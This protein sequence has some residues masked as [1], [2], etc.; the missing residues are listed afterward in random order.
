MSDVCINAL[1]ELELVV[2]H[3]IDAAAK[4]KP[5]ITK[6]TSSDA[7]SHANGRRQ[8]PETHTKLRSPRT[9]TGF[10]SDQAV[11]RHETLRVFR[12]PKERT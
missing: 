8:K 9:R 5:S 12:N 3:A 7:A 1:R 4:A 6:V 10:P 11:R 2:Q